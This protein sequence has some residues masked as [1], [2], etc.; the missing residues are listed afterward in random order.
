LSGGAD[1]RLDCGFVGCWSARYLGVLNLHVVWLSEAELLSRSPGHSASKRQGSFG[2]H[3]IGK[4]A[5]R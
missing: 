3:M 4:W 5:G 1:R 2:M